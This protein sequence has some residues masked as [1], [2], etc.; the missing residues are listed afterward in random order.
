MMIF[1]WFEKWKIRSGNTKDNLFK[2]GISNNI[3]MVQVI[4]TPGTNGRTLFDLVASFSVG[5]SLA[6]IIIGVRVNCINDHFK[7][8]LFAVSVMI[9]VTSNNVHL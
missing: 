8:P 6:L 7:I 9:I 3:G 4:N 5:L 2:W 1:K